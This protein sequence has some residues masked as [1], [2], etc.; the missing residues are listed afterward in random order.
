MPVVII[1]RNQNALDPER[2][3]LDVPDSIRRVHYPDW[4]GVSVHGSQV[5]LSQHPQPSLRANSKLKVL[6]ALGRRPS[7]CR[8][9][10]MRSTAAF[11]AKVRGGSIPG[12][13]T[14]KQCPRHLLA[15]QSVRNEFRF[16]RKS[17]RIRPGMK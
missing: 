3:S 1:A 12:S 2:A 4:L 7:I 16:P 11:Q 17:F 9:S 10:W 6:L 14:W 13:R 5:S 15:V 8:L